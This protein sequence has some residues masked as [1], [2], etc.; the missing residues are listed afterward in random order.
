MLVV[1]FLVIV[2][3]KPDH[4]KCWFPQYLLSLHKRFESASQVT[5]AGC[6]TTRQQHLRCETEFSET[7]DGELSRHNPFWIVNIARDR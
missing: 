7:E 6:S 2:P 1:L 4:P 5:E 3:T